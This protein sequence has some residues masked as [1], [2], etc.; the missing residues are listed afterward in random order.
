MIVTCEYCLREIDKRGLASHQ[1][2]H[3]DMA[4]RKL[5]N[6]WSVQFLLHGR[7]IGFTQLALPERSV[8]S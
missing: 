8:T 5:A 6:H 4:I 1:R 3:A 2:R 7:I